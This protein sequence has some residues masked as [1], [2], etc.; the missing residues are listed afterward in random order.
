[1]AALLAVPVLAV[2]VMIQSA[3]LSNIPLLHGTTD[4]VLVA[5]LAWALQKRVRTAWFW[6]IIGGLLVGYVSAL[7]FGA[8]L[9]GYL[10]A[11]GLAIL[12]KQR[13]WQVPILAMLVAT[14]F[15]TLLVNLVVITALRIVDTPLSF[16]EAINLVTLPSVL[17]NL[18]VAIPFYAL[19]S[20]LANWLYPEPLET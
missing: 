10:L 1:M 5:L 4:L 6:A 12:L 8:V 13:I 18:L 9:A 20:D 15:G 3:V 11:V 16:W 7:P 14:F 2:L 17:L 19:F